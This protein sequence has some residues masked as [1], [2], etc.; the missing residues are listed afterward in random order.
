VVTPVDADRR[1]ATVLFTD[2]VGS[3]DLLGRIGDEEYRQLR[4]QHERDARLAVEQGGGRL[5]NVAG[6]GTL[7]LFD[8]ATAAVRCAR[9]ICHRASDQQIQVR[10]GVH[11]GELEQSGTH[12][13][14]MTVHVGSRIAGLA[15]GGEVL[16]SRLVKDLLL[17]SELELQS[18]GT[19]ALKGVPGKH[20]LFVVLSGSQA[21]VPS[22]YQRLKTADRITLG[23]A[24]R[25]PSFTRRAVALGNA[26]QRM[27]IAS[28]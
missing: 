13:S 16:V 26:V 4:D 18:H 2:I 1:I 6:D 17:G 9:A 19:K 15:K 8:S 7:S 27:R 20:E 11:T 5:I 22:T 3:T 12:I 21:R 24:R 23:F 10:A 25:A 28:T 14:G